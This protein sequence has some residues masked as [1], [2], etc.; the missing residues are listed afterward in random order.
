MQWP[1]KRKGGRDKHWSTEHYTL[2]LSNM[3]PT[4]TSGEVVRSEGISS[5]SSTNGLEV[6][7]FTQRRHDLTLMFRGILCC[8]SVFIVLFY[9]LVVVLVLDFYRI[10]NLFR[11]G[12]SVF[13]YSYKFIDTTTFLYLKVQK[14]NVR[15]YW[16][17]NQQWPIKKQ[18]QTT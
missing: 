8:S 3:T 2:E 14:I 16:R 17:G 1:K 5:S 6:D 12:H 15:G 18:I 11:L 7:I 9:L 4:K 10:E 13:V